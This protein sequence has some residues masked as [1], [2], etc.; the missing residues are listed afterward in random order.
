MQKPFEQMS[1][2]ELTA[3]YNK[4]LESLSDEELR[5]EYE[6]QSKQKGMPAIDE[7]A[8]LSAEIPEEVFGEAEATP[9]E[10]IGFVEA[11]LRTARQ[12]ASGATIGLSE[13]AAFLPAD[14]ITKTIID[15]MER[16]D[17]DTAEK[18]ISAFKS[19][20][21][22]SRLRQEEYKEQYPYI[23]TAAEIGGG[24][25][26]GS[27]SMMLGAPA[28]KAPTLLKAGADLVKT[29]AKAGLM[30]EASQVASEAVGDEL[31]AGEMA[32][33]Y[34]TGT[35]VGAVAAPATAVGITAVGMGA[36]L[37]SKAAVNPVTMFLNQVIFG[38]K[39]ATQ[40]EFIKLEK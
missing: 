30:Y 38:P 31:T 11:G 15:A 13:P 40:K 26:P 29:G 2:E 7:E 20:W 3:A 23:S 4:R 22:K 28:L 34:A 33:R 12:A 27:P 25:I 39:I 19:N 24:F 37:L 36:E 35:A 6:S 16:G 9:Q 8:M 1:D 10:P 14:A 21:E 17:I 5:A 18:T 32:K